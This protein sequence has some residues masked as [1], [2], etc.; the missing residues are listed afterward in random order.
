MTVTNA[1]ATPTSS[2]WLSQPEQ[3]AHVHP[4]P[5]VGQL[6]DRR[7]VAPVVDVVRHRRGLPGPA[8][9]RWWSTGRASRSR[10]HR[11]PRP[12]PAGNVISSGVGHRSDPRPRRPR[13]SRSTRDPRSPVTRRRRGACSCP[14]PYRVADVASSSDGT[15]VGDVRA[16]VGGPGDTGR[17]KEQQHPE[18]P[19]P[20]G[21]M[22]I[23]R[24]RA[25]PVDAT[26]DAQQP[27]RSSTAALSP[28]P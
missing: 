26:V 22:P 9:P 11:C 27:A 14:A 24:P 4:D 12:G 16:G 6:R 28:W 23:Q 20:G 7:I 10:R 25:G 18:D 21:A 17:R 19:N 15:D 2:S 5:P 13:R 8:R 3:E 1:S